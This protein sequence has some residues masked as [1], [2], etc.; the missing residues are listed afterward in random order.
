MRHF[1]KILSEA[2]NRH[3]LKGD[4]LRDAM[5]EIAQRALRLEVDDNEEEL[6]HLAN[7]MQELKTE[8]NADEFERYRDEIVRRNEDNPRF[9]K[10][11]R[12]RIKQGCDLSLWMFKHLVDRAQK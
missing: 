5:Y 12:K 7:A 3:S 4:D 10:I 1:D 8:E 11:L 9:S 2:L 6:D